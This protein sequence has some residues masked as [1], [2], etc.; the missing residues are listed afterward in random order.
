MVSKKICGQTFAAGDPIPAT[1]KYSP[2]GRS[3]KNGNCYD[4][5]GGE[6]FYGY[7]YPINFASNTGFDEHETDLMYAAP[8]VAQC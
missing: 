5:N 7:D 2:S 3:Y 6:M 8:T 1:G 4:V